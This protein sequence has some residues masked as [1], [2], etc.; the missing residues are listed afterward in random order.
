MAPPPSIPGPVLWVLLPLLAWRLYARVR[1]MVGR[2]TSKAWRHWGAAVLFPLLVLAL[3][4]GTL[5][6]PLRLSCLLA[7]AAGGVGLG[8]WGLR[9]TRFEQ[10]PQGLYYTPSAHIGVALSLLLI[11]RIGYRLWHVY[12][13][14]SAYGV[15]GLQSAQDGAEFARSPLTLLVLGLLAGYYAAY[16]MGLLRWRRRVA[17]AGTD[18]T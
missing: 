7:A 12:G 4:L 3:A 10:G 6:D 1:R 2:Q 8:V 16:A 17:M 15:Q 18:G 11:A 5:A 9:L 13:L 14:Y